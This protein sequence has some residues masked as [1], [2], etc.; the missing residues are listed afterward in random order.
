MAQTEKGVL[1]ET[2]EQRLIALTHGEKEGTPSKG[3][4]YGLDLP[5]EERHVNL[6]GVELYAPACGYD[7]Y[8]QPSVEA[9]LE[10]G[11]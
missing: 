1:A 11:Q 4:L 9:A 2:H 8:V 6:T 10:L 3:G 5:I 7:T